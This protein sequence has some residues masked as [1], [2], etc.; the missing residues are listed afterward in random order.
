M[1]IKAHIDS[2][3]KK[4]HELEEK[5][6]NAYKHHRSDEALTLKREKLSIKD[7]IAALERSVHLAKAA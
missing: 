6:Y 3:Y 4:H 7:E 2:L 5:I 1:S